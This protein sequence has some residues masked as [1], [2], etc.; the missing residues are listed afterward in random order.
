MTKFNIGNSIL[1]SSDI[2]TK[3]NPLLQT[4]N[5]TE[6]TDTTQNI[7]STFA[8]VIVSKKA[9]NV[10]DNGHLQ[11]KI[12]K[13]SVDYI[14]YQS[15]PTNYLGKITN[16]IKDTRNVKEITLKELSKK[17]ITGHAFTNS[18]ANTGVKDKDFISADIVCLDFDGNIS[19]QEVLSILEKNNIIANI[20]YYT[21]SHGEKGERFRVITALNKTITDKD[22]YKCIIKGYMSLFD[23]NV[24]NATVGLVQRFLG[25]NKGLA[26]DV[27]ET[28]TTNKQ[29]FLDLYKKNC[30]IEKQ[31][32][33]PQE[34]QKNHRKNININDFDLQKEIDNYNLLDY[35][36]QTYPTSEFKHASGGVYVN[37]C[38]LCGHNDHL[39]ITGNKFHSFGN[40]ACLELG[41]V[42][43]IQWLQYAENLTIGQA[44]AK[45]K[46]E[47]L[48]IDEKQDKRAYAQ[49]MTKKEENNQSSNNSN[50]TQKKPYFKIES[51]EKELEE[52]GI[53]IKFNQIANSKDF[54][55]N[56][57]KLSKNEANEIPTMLYS[58]LC[59]KYKSININLVGLYLNTI[60]KKS[61]YNPVLDLFNSNQWDGQDH[62]TK[63]Y[64]VLNIA[65]DDT[66]SRTLL[67]KWFWQGHAL[68]RNNEENPFG[69]DGVLVLTGKQGIGKTSFFAHMAINSKFFREGQKL[70]S[71]DKD[72]ERRCI[73]TWIAELGEID[74]TFKFADMG[75]LKAFIT[76]SFD[77]YRLPY[78]R[79]DEQSARRANF[80]ATVNGDKFL[81]DKTGNRRFWTVSIESI[82]LND[83]QEIN[84]LQV[85]LQ[86]WEQYAKHN[87][88]GFRLT[89]TEQE[90]LSLRNKVCEKGI[91]GEAEVLDILSIA[92]QAESGYTMEYMTVSQFKQENDIL[93]GYSV[94]QL[95]KVLDSLGI[96]RGN[97]RIDGK[98]QRVRLLPKRTYPN[99]N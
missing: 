25:T 88:Q 4:D 66:L 64:D 12:V 90:L 5:V 83:L 45:F 31:E 24:D 22:E 42:G 50:D 43:I 94:E 1:D 57:N 10:N 17:I 56:N 21:Y 41:G 82:N 29:I 81:I 77:E 7:D 35:I 75:M 68:L 26:R 51:L 2:D 28:S 8:S 63:V 86:V 15:K 58:E 74:T 85:W 48:G 30:K 38:P 93:R 70:S 37:P 11:P 54:F 36:K 92:E 96:T 87:L 23:K 79:E 13:L 69:A 20:I 40:K 19:I 97:K 6:G 47:L 91:K 73:T 62:L 99:F 76:K 53:E 52:R 80:A 34:I 67:L 18:Y 98:M 59:D 71:F 84:A 72:T 3:Q 39:H 55:K 27:D 60:G 32:Q 78:G 33:K 65:N 61:K 49:A 89:K 95:G 44:I 46:Y 16:R 9:P 14:G